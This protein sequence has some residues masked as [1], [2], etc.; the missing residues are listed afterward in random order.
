[1]L[2]IAIT[3]F[4]WLTVMNAWHCEPFDS[5]F[6]NSFSFD[7][8][9]LDEDPQEFYNKTL[10]SRSS[11]MRNDGSVQRA[12]KAP[13]LP[14]ALIPIAST[15]KYLGSPLLD[16]VD[17]ST[18]SHLSI[19][20][21][22]FTPPLPN[23]QFNFPFVNKPTLR[24]SN[25]EAAPS[26]KRPIPP[27]IPKT[28]DKERIPIIRPDLIPVS[29]TKKKTINTPTF[30]KLPEGLNYSEPSNSLSSTTNHSNDT[31]ELVVP[32]VRNISHTNVLRLL[33]N[34]NKHDYFGNNKPLLSTD[35]KTLPPLS[36]AYKEEAIK[37]I[38]APSLH[39]PNQLPA[40]PV[41][42]AQLPVAQ[43]PMQTPRMI[44]AAPVQPP[45]VHQS[46]SY[47][48]PL[49]SNDNDIYDTHD[50]SSTTFVHRPYDERRI[51]KQQQVTEESRMSSGTFVAHGSNI[52][53]I[54]P[55]HP[56]PRVRYILGI[57]W[58][59]HVYLI[60]VLFSVL[61]CLSV[62]SL[63]RVY[64]YKWLLSYSYFVI[65]HSLLIV[66]GAVRSIY[67]FYDAYNIDRSFSK[68]VNRL[69]LNIVFPLLI[70]LFSLMFVFI[71]KI[72]DMKVNVYYS[73]RKS[74]LVL[75]LALAYLALSVSIDLFADYTSHAVNLLLVSQCLFVAL[76]ILLGL[77]YIAFYKYTNRSSL[78]K[79]NSVYGT[80]FT[81][82]LRPSLAHA[83]RVML[84]TSL[85]SLLIAA[86]LLIGML[87]IYDQPHPWLWWAFQ[88][89]VRV[90]EVS[91][92]FLV[93]WAA[94]QPLYGE[95]VKETQ[96]HNS[97]SSF[98]LFPWGTTGAA[99]RGSEHGH[100]D[101]VYPT[102]S[103]ANQVIHN[104]KYVKAF[105]LYTFHLSK[106]NVVYHIMNFD[107][108][109][110]VIIN[111]VHLPKMDCFQVCSCTCFMVIRKINKLEARTN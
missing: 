39:S 61:A 41:H 23:N 68:P 104:Y 102:I 16:G 21:N 7:K 5:G 2:S 107:N 101:D 71:L 106:E 42:V 38:G 54:L 78:R 76:C 40:P 9:L 17:A 86:I 105:I 20:R 77:A 79:Q 74:N 29:D 72:V 90:I 59:I 3:L 100:V 18:G 81:D 70:C 51:V 22:F 25:S 50:D 12:S 65:V 45:S 85:L 103:T 94:V 88:L 95:D 34:S 64:S 28:V 46:P 75:L 35:L 98:P 67:L 4:L 53:N 60:A 8:S 66:I 36:K 15:P 30:Q 1:M 49:P 44:P 87:C 82:P 26:N 32:I 19:N 73:G 57:A 58:N 109:S 69:M 108:S 96:S 48:Y 52:V 80:A 91:I 11:T 31:F 56:E 43:S 99:S 110:V 63:L 10:A 111:G 84:A 92:C 55:E 33:D 24:G 62:F 47:A 37:Q 83:I 27:S 13:V 97:A 93:F 89:S 14:S 6:D